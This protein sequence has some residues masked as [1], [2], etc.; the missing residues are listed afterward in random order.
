MCIFSEII[1]EV[2]VSKK[3]KKKTKSNHDSD[4]IKLLRSSKV[5]LT[6]EEKVL[7]NIRQKK[8]LRVKKSTIDIEKINFREIAVDGDYILS[9]E[10]TKAWTNKWTNREFRY[11]KLENGLLIEEGFDASKWT[12]QEL[13]EMNKFANC[14]QFFFF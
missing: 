9:G 12:L 7:E 10:G 13:L 14:K 11:K 2:V 6:H 1:E 4:G 5:N 8:P 3:K